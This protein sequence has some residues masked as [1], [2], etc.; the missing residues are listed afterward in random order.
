MSPSNNSQTNIEKFGLDDQTLETVPAEQHED[1]IDP[2]L[3]KQ[4]LRKIDW[5]LLAS[6]PVDFDFA[7]RAT[8]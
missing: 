8:C 2:V 5:H 4:L 6:H 3:Q 1:R 7:W